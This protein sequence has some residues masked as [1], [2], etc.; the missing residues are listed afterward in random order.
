MFLL[1][2]PVE[3]LCVYESPP[4]FFPCTDAYFS[5]R[6]R[7][8]TERFA[9]SVYACIRLCPAEIAPGRFWFVAR[10]LVRRRVP[11]LLCILFVG[12]HLFPYLSRRGLHRLLLAFGVLADDGYHH[13][14]YK[15]QYLYDFFH[16]SKYV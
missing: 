4:C 14:N 2:F 16:T 1:V 12:K 8:C 6:L 3:Y 13:C 7:G 9:C 11:E 10:W 5:C 15:Y